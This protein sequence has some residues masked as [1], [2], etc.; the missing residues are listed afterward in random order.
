[1]LVRTPE[2]AQ[3]A[4][5]ILVMPLTFASSA[6]VPTDTMPT[7]AARL[8]REPAADPGHQHRPR[9]DARAIRPAPTPGK[10]SPGR[11]VS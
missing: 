11:S 4:M 7:G 2:A 10:P 8:R 9:L 3:G 5:F 6:F 1:M